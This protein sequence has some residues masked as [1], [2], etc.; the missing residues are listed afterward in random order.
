M[1]KVRRLKGEPL[2]VNAELIELVEATPD[3]ML[4]LTTGRKLM[5]EEAVNDVVEAVLHYRKLIHGLPILRERGEVSKWN[6]QP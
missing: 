1:I 5:V 3:T 2:Y 4:T 6:S